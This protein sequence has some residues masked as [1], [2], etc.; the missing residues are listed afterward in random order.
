MEIRSLANTDTEIIVDA[1]LNAFA[2]YDVKIGRT[3][4]KAM[5]KRRGFDASLSFAAFDG[6]QIVAFTLNGIGEFEGIPTAYDT[7]TGTLK[8]YRGQG[9]APRIF[10][11]SIDYLKANGVRQY[12][13]EVLQ[14]NASAVS[15]YRKLGF[16]VTREF[17]CFGQKADKVSH[18]GKKPQMEYEIKPFRI[19]DKDKLSAWWDFNPSWQNSFESID[20]SPESFK[21]LGIFTDGKLVGYGVLEPSSG[22]L[23]QIAVDPQY[24]RKGLA[25]ALIDHML[26]M[27][28]YESVKALNIDTRCEALNRL[29]ES[30]N[31]ELTATQYEMIRPL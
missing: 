13:L 31:M 6:D 29:L 8:Q 15:V 2:D 12:L 19:E 5:L 16:E 17:N 27:T 18:S 26:R 22:D 11:H 14:H 25:S 24:R 4:L 3:Q 23:P 9:L 10:E 7:G 1:F 20:R 21:T 30:K 28:E